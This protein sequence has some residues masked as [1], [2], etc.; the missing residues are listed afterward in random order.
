MPPPPGGMRPLRVCLGPAAVCVL[1]QLKRPSYRLCCTAGCG[2]S[3][4][5]PQYLL[6]AG[7]HKIAVT[8]VG[9]ALHQ[10]VAA[11]AVGSCRLVTRRLPMRSIAVHGAPAAAGM[12]ARWL[13]RNFC[14]ILA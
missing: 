5:I 4:Q 2:K 12:H 13:L 8:Q 11:V 14:T 9:G 10:G 3:T 7:W 1:A 6:A